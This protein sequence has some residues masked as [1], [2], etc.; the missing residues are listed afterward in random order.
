VSAAFVERQEGFGWHRGMLI[1][2]ATMR[3]S[4]LKD[5]VTLRDPTSPFSFLAYLHERG[6]LVDFINYGSMY[7]TR[8]E[9]HDYLEWAA[10]RCGAAVD[11]GTEVLGIHPARSAAGGPIDLLEIVGRR[12]GITWRRHARNVVLATGLTAHLPAGVRA[13]RRIWH[14]RDLLIRVPELDGADPGRFVVVGAGQSA[15]EAVDHLHRT[16]PAAESA[17]C[18]AATATAR[19]TTAASPTGSSTRPPSTTTSTRPAR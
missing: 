4:F 17:R 13:G 9:F 10:G 15:A 14:H 19:P 1:E 7:P 8:L 16:F 5:L 6:R 12:C 18:S 3:I 11:Y 2:D